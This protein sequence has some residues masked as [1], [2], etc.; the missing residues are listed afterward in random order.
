MAIHG[1]FK[2]GMTVIVD[3]LNRYIRPKMKLH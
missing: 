1:I 2:T 3:G